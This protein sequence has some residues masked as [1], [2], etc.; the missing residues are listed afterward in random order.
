MIVDWPVVANIAEPVVLL[1]IGAWVNCWFERRPDNVVP[2]A[3]IPLNARAPRPR[4]RLPFVV[5]P[6]G[7]TYVYECEECGWQ[8]RRCADGQEGRK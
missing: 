8:V 6:E 5:W 2:H 1:F 4:M 3:I 7:R